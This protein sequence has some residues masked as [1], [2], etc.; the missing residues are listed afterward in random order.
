MLR[1][2]PGVEVEYKDASLQALCLQKRK[3]QK[4]LGGDCARKL[5]A[6]LADLFAVSNPTELVAGRPHPLKG[7][8]E[9]WFSVS[10]NKKVRLCFEPAEQPWP[11]M[12]DGGI[13]WAAV[14]RVVVVWV[15]DYHDE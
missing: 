3:A 9:G 8:R 13:A 11:R 10:L 4:A 15:G 2:G 5:R 12:P 6:R 1:M 7:N 14:D